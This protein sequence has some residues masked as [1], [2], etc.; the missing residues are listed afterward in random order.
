MCCYVRVVVCDKRICLQRLQINDTLIALCKLTVLVL[1]V[2][3]LW[4]Y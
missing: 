2:V 1:C 3:M 4:D